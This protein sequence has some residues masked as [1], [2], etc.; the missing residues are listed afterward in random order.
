MAKRGKKGVNGGNKTK[1]SPVKKTDGK[2][3]TSALGAEVVVEQPPVDK[4]GGETESETTRVVASNE[5]VPL[6]EEQKSVMKSIADRTTTT[7]FITN[8]VGVTGNGE[9]N[10]VVKT[11][12]MCGPK[13]QDDS[14]N[15]GKRDDSEITTQDSEEVPPEQ[16][17]NT[18]T[19]EAPE[20]KETTSSSAD[21]A[22][23]VAIPM[24]TDD[25]LQREAK[26]SCY[27]CR[28]TNLHEG[29]DS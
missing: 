9:K 12:F 10:V 29:D 5:C 4:T 23:I 2:E 11:T 13:S 7:S 22:E 19:L 20:E 14:S 27:D 16:G 21:K 15:E 6:S 1:P 3:S 17:S 8:K 26:N 24:D 28:Y 18:D 25:D